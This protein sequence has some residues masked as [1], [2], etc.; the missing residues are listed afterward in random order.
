M[1]VSWYASV[2]DEDYLWVSSFRYNGLYKIDLQNE[3]IH[4]VGSFP[5]YRDESGELHLFAKSFNDKLYFFPQHSRAIDIY[6]CKSNHF[7]KIDCSTLEENQFTTMAGAYVKANQIYVIP[8]NCGM[9]LLIISS[10]DDA[11]IREV[12][13]NK[14]N[15]FINKKN[16]LTLYTCQVDDRIL[17]PIYDTNHIGV[18]N[19]GLMT[20]QIVTS[21]KVNRI[22]GTLA[23]NDRQLWIN[24]DNGMYCFDIDNKE[25]LNVCSCEDV[26]EGWI[27]KIIFIDDLVI[28][29][30]RWLGNICVINSKTFENRILRIDENRLHVLYEF[31][32]RDIKDCFVWKGKIYISPMR[33]KEM[34]VIDP[35]TEE[36]EYK[37]Y[38]MDFSYK[39]KDVYLTE[40]YSNDLTAFIEMIH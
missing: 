18:F 16:F 12:E 4:F 3:D 23:V 5:E 29:I 31:P 14:A 20:E 6:D 8:R 13:L 11:I 34:I 32:F 17:F 33:Y 24:A 38:D 37:L 9:P 40:R 26:K 22:Q 15:K 28:C 1:K 19:M 21:S 10:Q 2:L 25:L 39:Q 36:I 27:E 30:P 35:F 7:L